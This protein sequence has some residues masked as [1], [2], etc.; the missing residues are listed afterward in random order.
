MSEGEWTAGWICSV[1][2]AAILAASAGWSA[3]Q[4]SGAAAAAAAGLCGALVAYGVFG[5]IERAGRR[6]RLPAFD[7]PSF[8]APEAADAGRASNV[9]AIGAWPRARRSPG[10]LD[11]TSRIQ[12][13]GNRKPAEVIPLG[14]DASAALRDALARLKSARS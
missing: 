7:L 2:S 4:V 13:N 5:R 9:V 1:P 3:G 10:E 11:R 6:F 12:A 8:P 14:A